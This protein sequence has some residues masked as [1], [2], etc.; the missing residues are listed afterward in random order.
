MT[1]AFTKRRRRAAL[2][3]SRCKRIP[4]VL[5]MV[6]D[7]V[8]ARFMS[9]VFFTTVAAF[10]VRQTLV[11]LFIYNPVAQNPAAPALVTYEPSEDGPRAVVETGSLVSPTLKVR[12]TDTTGHGAAGQKVALFAL[13]DDHS[14]MTNAIQGAWRAWRVATGPPVL[15]LRAGLS[16]TSMDY[17]LFAPK[18]RIEFPR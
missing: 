10:V 17:T 8:Q 2:A 7:R 3:L 12:V 1:S 4:I 15:I 9:A 11:T 18:G 13:P 5:D 6:G 14:V 16:G